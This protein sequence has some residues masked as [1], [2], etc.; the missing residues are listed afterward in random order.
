LLTIADDRIKEKAMSDVTLDYFDDVPKTLAPV[1]NELTRLLDPEAQAAELDRDLAETRAALKYRPAEMAAAEGAA[2]AERDERRRQAVGEWSYTLQEV[3]KATTAA[4]LPLLGAADAAPGPAAVWFRKTNKFASE[5]EQLQLATLD[6]LRV[7]RF[8]RELPVSNPAAVRAKYAVA[9]KDPHDQEHASLIRWVE[10]RYAAGWTGREL[11]ASEAA[12]VL[13]LREAIKA[14]QLA[15]R[16]PAAA[17]AFEAL[18]AADQLVKRAVGTRI[19]GKP[20]QKRITDW[21]RFLA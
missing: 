9:L 10:A 5:T 3:T 6:E 18:H 8:D 16:P 15:R 14:A 4:M 13:P 7:A 11:S 17:K 1:V 12:G 21:R 2:R 20:I 19:G